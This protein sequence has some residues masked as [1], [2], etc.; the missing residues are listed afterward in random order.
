MSSGYDQFF[1][2]A[3]RAANGEK[4]APQAQPQPK[5]PTVSSLLK[6]KRKSRPFPVGATFISL[7]GFLSA[8]YFFQNQE[9]VLKYLS[10]IEISFFTT[11]SAQADKVEKKKTEEMRPTEP[12][13]AE[14]TGSEL[15]HLTKLVERKKE[16]DAREEELSRVEA[17]LSEQK[18]AL[19]RRLA[20]L[21]QMRTNISSML[22]DRVKADDQKIETLV[23]FYSN[24]KPP[25]AAKIF[26]TIDE[27]L[28]VQILGR[29][30]KKNAA[31]IL[32]LI[33][34][35]KAQMFTEKFAGYKRTTASAPKPEETKAETEEEP[36]MAQQP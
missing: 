11:A 27:D 33:K 35:E 18:A 29:M 5:G 32:N 25:Q 36:S 23:Q 1:K 16:L 34:P 24:M 21:E 28:A 30:K 6:K 9:T 31:D 26:E 8:L 7:I 15:G 10:A 14:P 3:R 12:V 4:P 20:E 19:Q 13:L 22:E 2:S 17:E